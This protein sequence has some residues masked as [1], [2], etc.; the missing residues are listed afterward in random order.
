MENTSGLRGGHGLT[1]LNG[2]C[3]VDNPRIASP[4]P[5]CRERRLHGL[6]AIDFACAAL[7]VA[8]LKAAVH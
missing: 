6:P 8:L 1:R 4:Y 3:D 5:Y 7:D 2:S